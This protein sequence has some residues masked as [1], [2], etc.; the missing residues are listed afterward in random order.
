[1][2][3]IKID[4]RTNLGFDTYESDTLLSGASSGEEASSVVDTIE[5]NT[6]GLVVGL[7]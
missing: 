6:N 4:W 2:K 3:P 5:N 1:M 7:R